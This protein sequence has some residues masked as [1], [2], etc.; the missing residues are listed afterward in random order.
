MGIQLS[1]FIATPTAPFYI[2][3]LPLTFSKKML[4]IYYILYI[5][6]YTLNIS[7]HLNDHRDHS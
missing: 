6:Y 2:V 7:Y 3:L 5:Y 1:L 4:S